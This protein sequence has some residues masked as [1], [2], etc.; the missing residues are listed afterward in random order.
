MK[1]SMVYSHKLLELGL[2]CYGK[3]GAC[4]QNLPYI[5]LIWM[6]PVELAECWVGRL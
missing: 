2:P 6:A 5:D 1:G 3:H 4:G